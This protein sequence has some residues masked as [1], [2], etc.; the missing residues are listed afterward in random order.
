MTKEYF[1]Q[2]NWKQAGW[3]HELNL[4]KKR[5]IPIL[6][7][8]KDSKTSE[9]SFTD[10]TIKTDRGYLTYKGTL[11]DVYPHLSRYMLRAELQACNHFFVEEANDDIENKQRNTIQAAKNTRETNEKALAERIHYFLSELANTWTDELVDYPAKTYQGTLKAKIKHN[12]E[13]AEITR[14]AGI[15]YRANG[16]KIKEVFLDSDSSWPSKVYPDIVLE[17]CILALEEKHKN[18]NNF[19]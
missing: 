19:I 12:I 15:Y 4:D 18:D 16:M 6:R 5:T 10:Y 1:E 9:Y 2:L 3:K 13:P 11:D 8:Y 14:A 7:V 17:A